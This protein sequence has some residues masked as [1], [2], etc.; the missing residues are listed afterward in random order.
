MGFYVFAFDLQDFCGR[1]FLLNH[2]FGSFLANAEVY[3]LT[4][5]PEVET[6]VRVMASVG[7]NFIA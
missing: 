3:K 2:F 1:F 6:A 7:F 5:K 4:G